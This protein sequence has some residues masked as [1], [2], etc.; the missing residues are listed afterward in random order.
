MTYP[1]MPQED[2]WLSDGPVYKSGAAIGYRI[3][4][5]PEGEEA[6]IA[7]FAGPDQPDWRLLRTSGGKSG[8]W[9]G[10]YETVQDALVA[11]QMELQ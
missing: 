6:R 11:L 5:M 2:A 10:H 7:N 3:T 1:L 4:G 9:S 8:D